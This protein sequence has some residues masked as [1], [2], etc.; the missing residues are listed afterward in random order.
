M[1]NILGDIMNVREELFKNQDEKNNGRFGEDEKTLRQNIR[2]II[3]ENSSVAGAKTEAIRYILLNAKV[4]IA[5]ED[6]FADKI[7]HF[8]I[9]K[10]FLNERIELLKQKDERKTAE[11]QKLLEDTGCITAGFD[12]GH[13]G[14]DWDFLMQNGISKTIERLKEFKQ[15]NKDKKE[16][17]DRCITVYKRYSRFFIKWQ[18]AAKA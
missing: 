17:Y 7:E 11:K 4:D 18:N 16:F 13:I 6:I 8:D 14:P 1:Y 12:F 5:E 2:K 3:N 10:D 15:K 9:M